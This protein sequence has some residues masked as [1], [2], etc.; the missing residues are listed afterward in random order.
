MYECK[1]CELWCYKRAVLML[2]D[3]NSDILSG[4]LKYIKGAE[5][6]ALG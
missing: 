4:N 1:E 5:T 3:A 6:Q 2:E